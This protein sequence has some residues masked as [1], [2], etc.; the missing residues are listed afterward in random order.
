M[1]GICGSTA[2]PRGDAARRMAA[3]MTHR[4]PDDDGFH[5]DPSG[6]A[7]GARRLSVIDVEGGH[8]PVRNEDGTVWAVLNGEIYNHRR[9]REGLRAAGHVF[10]SE[11]DTEV[12]VHLYEHYG[13]AMVHALEGMYAFAVWDARDRELLLCRDRFGE[14]PLFYARDGGTLVFASELT[15][16]ADGLGDVPAVRADVVDAF[17]ILGYVPGTSAIRAGVD[18]LAPGHLL[19]WSAREPDREPER[20]WTLPPRS[21]VE[22]RSTD[23]LVAELEEVFDDAVRSRLVADVP[24]GLFLSGGVDS[25]LVAAVA[26]HA[27]PGVLKT[28]TVG[29]DVGTVNELDTARAA[30]QALGTDHHEV[31]L[32][33]E[34][35]AAALPPL[36]AGLDQP[37]ADPA[38]VALHEVAGLARERVTVAVGG[39]G[40]DELFGGYPRYR[41]LARADTLGRAMPAPLAAGTVRAGQRVLPN[42]RAQRLTHVMAPAPSTER[43]LDWVTDRRRQ[44][45]SALYGERLLD[46]AASAT[47]V[48]DA[49]ACLADTNGDVSDRFMRLDQRR[50]LPDNVLMKAD[51]AGMLRSLEVRTPYLERSLA[52]FAAAI[53]T[54]HHLR[55]GGKA[56]LRRLLPRLLPTYKDRPKTAFRIPLDDWLRGPL[57]PL[58]DA[59][60]EGPLVRDG[61]ID[62]RGFAD[63]VAEHRAGR[64]E[65]AGLVWHLLT[66]GLWL[67][68][69]GDAAA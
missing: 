63:A 69:Q 17:L 31:L 24:V 2:D 60:H 46:W 18:Q 43:H 62:Q 34:G 52:E 68:G 16:L 30:A 15:A 9:L 37:L 51:R 27:V 47:V 4:G 25:T 49:D 44:A 65:R 1:C 64:V 22:G 67:E 12:L 19:R 11:T 57:A 21:K 39:E 33:G 50:F 59:Q 61:W 40:A 23:H 20:Y 36:M 54:H 45:R 58:V 55:Q 13:S 66:L 29:Y 3:R 42:G 35:A 48:G 28:F 56:L 8:Q 38:L 6:V 53:P 5:V 14:K 41:W 10:R 26:A 32:T 7:L